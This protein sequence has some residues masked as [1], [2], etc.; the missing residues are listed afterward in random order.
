MIGLDVSCEEVRRVT[1]DT[2]LRW[3]TTRAHASALYPLEVLQRLSLTF[4]SDFSVPPIHVEVS[5][6][7]RGL[8]HLCL[9]LPC[10]ERSGPFRVSA[11]T[12]QSICECGKDR[13]SE[14]ARLITH[15]KRGAGV[16]EIETMLADTLDSLSASIFASQFFD[17]V[18]PAITEARSRMPH[19]GFTKGYLYTLRN[20]AASSPSRTKALI[21]MKTWAK[22]F[23][24]LFADEL[25]AHYRSFA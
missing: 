8:E 1:E 19:P 12:S 18:L 16:S 25:G 3:G 6:G 20:Q 15:G 14:R 10:D 5:I 4:S 2:V 17:S 22:P 11:G 7:L 21:Q 23:P 13:A 24:K 9:S